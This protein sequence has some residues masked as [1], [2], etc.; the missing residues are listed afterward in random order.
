[1]IYKDTDNYQ[2]PYIFK[3]LIEKMKKDFDEYYNQICKQYNELQMVLKDL[4][5]EVDEGIIEPERIDQLK[6]TISPI[7]NS[8]KILSYI[9][10]LLDKPCKSKKN[11]IEKYKHRNKKLLE[12]SKGKTQQEIQEEN[13]KILKNLSF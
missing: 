2:Y 8:Y 3:R 4:S 6:V 11:K 12:I 5:K 9:K 7:E 10:Y 1:M 13:E